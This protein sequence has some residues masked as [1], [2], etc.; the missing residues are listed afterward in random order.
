[1]YLIRQRLFYK[2]RNKKQK[3]NYAKYY[4]FVIF[5]IVITWHNIAPFFNGNL[6]PLKN[7]IFSY[8][9]VLT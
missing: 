3:I 8:I 6:I 9:Y 1:M 4:L 7:G 5:F 2:C